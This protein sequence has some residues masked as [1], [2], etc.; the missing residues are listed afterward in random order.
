[1]NEPWLNTSPR[2]A[3]GQEWKEQYE[4]NWASQFAKPE[5]VFLIVPNDRLD[6]A[7]RIAGTVQ[8]E[9][10][11]SGDYPL[12]NSLCFFTRFIHPNKPSIN[13]LFLDAFIPHAIIKPGVVKMG[14]DHE[15][16]ECHVYYWDDEYLYVHHRY[17]VIRADLHHDAKMTY[18]DKMLHNWNWIDIDRTAMRF[19]TLRL[20]QGNDDG[21]P[22]TN[23][24]GQ[25]WSAD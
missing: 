7:K 9:M 22:K 25:N 17:F 5:E 19:K 18:I 23:E 10:Q 24:Q 15:H 11:L 16:Q 12:H 4:S 21:L 13:K 2:L 6:E 14:K 1:M 20:L 3:S 8:D